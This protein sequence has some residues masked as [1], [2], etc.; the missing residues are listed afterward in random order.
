MEQEFELDTPD[1]LVATP[2]AITAALITVVPVFICYFEGPHLP[3]IPSFDVLCLW[4]PFSIYVMT[5]AVNS[6]VKFYADIS[7][8]Y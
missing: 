5:I 4:D 6:L 3:I 1:A 2:T 8:Y 7:Y